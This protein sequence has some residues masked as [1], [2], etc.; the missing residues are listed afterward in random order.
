LLIEKQEISSE[1]SLKLVESAIKASAASGC[2]VCVA[3]VDTNG[4][5]TALR[6]MDA[7][8][9][10]VTDF[11]LDKAYTAVMTRKT[12]AAFFGRMDSSP[13][14]K[15][16]LGNRPRL[17]VWGG[18]LPLFFKD[19]IVGAIGVSGAQEHEDIQFAEAAVLEAGLTWEAIL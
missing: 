7:V 10:A 1:H 3:V 15:M 5:V 9:H 14:L 17:L 2:K 12:T 6:R 13:S 11:A 16:G 18:G 4:F 8:P 19:K